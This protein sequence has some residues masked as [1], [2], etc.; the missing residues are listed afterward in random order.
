MSEEVE[1]T[2]VEEWREREKLEEK[3]Q[4]KEDEEE[5]EDKEEEEDA[6]TTKITTTGRIKE[7][8]IE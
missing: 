3:E 2:G 1:R 5:G 6:I 4:K 7:G 8:Y